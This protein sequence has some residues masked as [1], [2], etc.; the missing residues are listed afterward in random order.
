M[1]RSLAVDVDGD[2]VGWIETVQAAVAVESR[3][4][5]RPVASTRRTRILPLFTLAG[6]QEADTASIA[7]S[8]PMAAR[9][10]RM[11]RSK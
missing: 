3:G 11:W 5:A 4:K 2:R 9:T 6:M 10:T 7:S 8:R 1:P